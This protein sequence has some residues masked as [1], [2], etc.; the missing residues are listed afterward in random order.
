MRRA[1]FSLVIC[2]PLLSALLLLAQDANDRPSDIRITRER[3]AKVAATAKVKTKKTISDNRKNVVAS[4]EDAEV[5][6]NLDLLQ[7]LELLQDYD[8]V[9]LLNMFLP[10]NQKSAAPNKAAKDSKKWSKSDDKTNYN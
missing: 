5:I 1:F 10:P 7:N 6:A 4:S 2:C 3:R 8:K 9:T